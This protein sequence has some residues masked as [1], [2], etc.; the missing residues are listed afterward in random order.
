MG[1]GKMGEGM[2]GVGLGLH[3]RLASLV[4]SHTSLASN[5]ANSP[6]RIEMT[7]K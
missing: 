5:A 2:D 4:F 7:V 3:R 1:A 6:N